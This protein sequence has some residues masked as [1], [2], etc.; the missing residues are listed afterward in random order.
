MDVFIITGTSQGLGNSLVKQLIRKEHRVYAISR[1]PSE[2][3]QVLAQELGC[4]Y[5]F[6]Q[7]DLNDTKELDQVMHTI[8]DSLKGHAF[9]SLNLVN[10]AGV[11]HPVGKV[12]SKSWEDIENNIHVNLLAPILLM[13]SFVSLTQSLAL[14]KRIINISSGAGKKPYTSWSSYCASKSGLNMFSEVLKLEQEKEAYPIEVLSLAPYIM[15]TNMQAS[16]RSSSKDDFPLRETFIG[17]KDQNLLLKSDQV[18]E[19]VIQILKGD[20]WP[21]QV[22]KDVRDFI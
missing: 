8:L 10:N 6:I 17:F 5:K 13:N 4:H 20:Q 19:I 2:D 1:R 15:D 9:E 14:K 16:L 18:A 11:V 7:K 12:G 22:I 3:L 21:D